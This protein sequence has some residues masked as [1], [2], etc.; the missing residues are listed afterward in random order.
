[1]FYL[2]KWMDEDHNEDHG[3]D[4]KDDRSGKCQCCIRRGGNCGK[5]DDEEAED[6]QFLLVHSL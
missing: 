5:G 1:M 3:A 6:V 4:G 2:L